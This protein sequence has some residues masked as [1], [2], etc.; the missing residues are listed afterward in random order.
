MKECLKGV[1]A[2]DIINA[3]FGDPS[4]TTPVIDGEFLTGTLLY[5]LYAV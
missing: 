5:G 1:S 3:G 2:E 4:F